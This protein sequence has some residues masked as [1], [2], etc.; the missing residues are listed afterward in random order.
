MNKGLLI[1]IVVF[2]ILLLG[3]GVFLLISNKEKKQENAGDVTK[4]VTIPSLNPSDIG[5][6]MM[7]SSNKKQVKFVINNAE[8]IDSVIY[9]ISYETGD[10]QIR[11]VD[12]SI[13]SKG[14]SKLESK[15][16]DL[17]SCSRNVCKYDTGVTEV[18]LIL[19]I[20]KDGKVYSAEDKLQL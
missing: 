6:E 3:G 8:G 2:I 20:T 5:L 18:S 11:G 12:G 4:D 17:G 15:Y 16:H 9:T 19:K 13:E 14:Q 7:A 1:G 10:G